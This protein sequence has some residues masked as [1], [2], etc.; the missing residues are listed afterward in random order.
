MGKKSKR[1]NSAQTK[2]NKGTALTAEVDAHSRELDFPSWWHSKLE[3]HLCSHGRPLV[4]PES[5]HAVSNFIESVLLDDQNIR[6]RFEVFNND[7]FRELAVDILVRIGTLV[8]NDCDD[9]A[10]G[11][12]KNI[13]FQI[14]FLESYDV[15]Q[16][17]D[18]YAAMYRSGMLLTVSDLKN[19]G[20]RE[21]IRFFTK[22]ISCSCLKVRYKQIKVLH[23]KSKSRCDNCEQVKDRQSLM[24]CG[25]CKV[26]QYCSIECQKA[27]WPKHKIGVCDKTVQYRR[28]PTWI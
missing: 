14:L 25:R 19:G 27:D 13:A 21:V 10:T 26:C 3:L 1:R 12:A 20:E 7:T 15:E 6:N 17:D 11:A 23:P 28:G 4:L 8:C 22:R 9:G 5:G 18:L 24:L 16:G 2:V